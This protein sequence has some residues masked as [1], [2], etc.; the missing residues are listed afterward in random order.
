MITYTVTSTETQTIY[1]IQGA[2]T[3][4][5]PCLYKEKE[6]HSIILRPKKR[7]DQ[8][9]SLLVSLYMGLHPRLGRDSPLQMLQDDVLGRISS[10][11]LS[12]L[13]VEHKRWDLKP[14]SG[15]SYTFFYPFEGEAHGYAGPENVFNGMR[16]CSCCN[17][18]IQE[19]LDD[20]AHA[21]DEDEKIVATAHMAED[22]IRIVQKLEEIAICLNPAL[23]EGA[24]SA[25]CPNLEDIA[26][27]LN[28]ALP[29]RS[30]SCP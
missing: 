19:Q 9:C 28:P 13:S 29:A 14:H 22:C 18:R 20:I 30:A 24:R 16:I 1:D 4:I 2:N 7:D 12:S 6:G 5:G 25:S 3:C 17:N 26:I 8:F 11:L 23:P 21:E 15:G 10:I 27:C